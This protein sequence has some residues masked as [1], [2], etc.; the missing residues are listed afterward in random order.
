MHELSTDLKSPPLAP[1]GCKSALAVLAQT[2]Y[3]VNVAR[4]RTRVAEFV[5]FLRPHGV[6]LTYS[7]TLSQDEYDVL[8]SG[9]GIPRKAAV[10]ARGAGRAA[11][12]AS[13][14]HDLLLVHRLRLLNPLPGIDPPRRLDVYDLDDALFVGFRTGVNRRFR[15]AKQEARRCVECMRRA[16]LVLAGNAFLADHARQFAPRVEILPTCVDPFRQRLRAHHEQQVVTV[17]WIGSPTTSPYLR[18]VLP[19]FARLNSNHL[20]ARLV[21]VGADRRITAP[22]IEHRPWSLDQERDQLAGFDIG[23]M[24]QPDDAWARGKCGYKV[25]QYFAAGVP[26]VASPVGITPSLIGDD[27]GLLASSADE[28]WAALDALIRDSAER[29]QRGAAGRAFVEQAYSYQRWAPELAG[30]LQS[31]AS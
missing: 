11:L 28:W 9:G 16:R 29:R 13:P 31:I 8:A 24:P 25:L 10:L 18:A 21:A 17:G 7:P 23:I 14:A 20:R 4:A 30:L 22:W 12:R 3:P 5:P 27:R 15:W 2:A 1:G 6:A 19:V 26:A